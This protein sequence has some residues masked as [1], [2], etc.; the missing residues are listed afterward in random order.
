MLARRLAPILPAMPLAQALA[1]TRL[2]RVT[3]LTRART[4]VVTTRPCRAAPHTI[5]E[6]GLS[7]GG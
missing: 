6:A 4:A 3:G 5:S 7:G 1:T 2:P